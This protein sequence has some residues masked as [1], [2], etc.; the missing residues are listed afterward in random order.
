MINSREQLNFIQ[1]KKQKLNLRIIFA[2]LL[3]AAVV[4]SKLNP[5]GIFADT[6]HSDTANVTKPTRRVWLSWILLA[7]VM[8]ALYILFN[9]H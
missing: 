7:C 4:I 5:S 9:G 8:I 6:T 3:I 1:V 2:I